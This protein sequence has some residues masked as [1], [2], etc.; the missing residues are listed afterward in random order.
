MIDEAKFRRLI[1][2]AV[3]EAL[4]E[5]KSELVSVTEAADLFRVK[6]DTIRRWA[7]AGRLRTVHVG[8]RLL[9]GTTYRSDPAKQ[10]SPEDFARQVMR[11]YG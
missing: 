1:V 8:R 3:R 7:R 5:P 10:P 6:P 4:S 9:V 11:K 2:D